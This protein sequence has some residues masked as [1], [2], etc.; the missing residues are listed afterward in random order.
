MKKS[1]LLE[2]TSLDGFIYAFLSVGYAERGEYEKALAGIEEMR[3]NP[4]LNDWT[5]DREIMLY[6]DY[7]KDYE[8]VIDV[9]G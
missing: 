6:R 1:L 2:V 9:C 7:L 3:K 8:K 4:E 5:S